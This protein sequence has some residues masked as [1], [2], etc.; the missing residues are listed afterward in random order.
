MTTS[1]PFYLMIMAPPC[2]S[3]D[4]NTVH[5]Q[6]HSSA[7]HTALCNLYQNSQ[8][9]TQ[10][11]PQHSTTTPFTDHNI[12]HHSQHQHSTPNNTS[13]GSAMVSI[14]FFKSRLKKKGYLS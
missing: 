8:C 6:H 5:S 9:T 3:T 14:K 11:I 1:K 10:H 7:H 2:S 4:H 13:R 12:A